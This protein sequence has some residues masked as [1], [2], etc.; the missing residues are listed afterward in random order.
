MDI[1]EAPEPTKSNN[2]IVKCSTVRVLKNATCLKI[3]PKPMHEKQVAA[4][5]QLMT[6]TFLIE[7][8]LK[9]NILLLSFLLVK[10]ITV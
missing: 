2:T 6:L 5:S 4:A 9:S 8:H 1:S 3:A 10:E 7:H